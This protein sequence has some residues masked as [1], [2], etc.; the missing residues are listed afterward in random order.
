MGLELIINSIETKHL[1]ESVYTCL[2]EREM[3]GKKKH[4][5]IHNIFINI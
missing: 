5:N 1:L 4:N 3:K 2:H